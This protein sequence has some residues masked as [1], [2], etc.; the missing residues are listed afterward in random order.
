MVLDTPLNRET[1]DPYSRLLLDALQGDCTLAIRGDE[2]WR[3]VDLFMHAWRA[4][5][6]PLFQY[7]AGASG[8][9]S[10]LP[11]SRYRLEKTRQGALSRPG[12]FPR[13]AAL[14]RVWG[15]RKAEF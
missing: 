2:A 13:R 12:V 3:I 7:T 15:K 4:G 5:Y 14:L 10:A 9:A 1:R 8:P 11:P 6:A